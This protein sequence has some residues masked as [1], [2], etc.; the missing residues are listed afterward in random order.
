MR[1]SVLSQSPSGDKPPETDV[2]KV[3]KNAQR[4]Y[5]EEQK[6]WKDNEEMIQKQMAEDREKQLKEYVKLVARSLASLLT[7]KSRFATFSSQ[8]EG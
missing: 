7:C 6:Y 4:M 8:D 3:R 1:L 2:E 5:L